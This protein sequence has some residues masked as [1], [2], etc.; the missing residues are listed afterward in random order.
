MA[1]RLVALWVWEDAQSKRKNVRCQKSDH[2]VF[3]WSLRTPPR[4]LGRSDEKFSKYR[5]AVSVVVVR[6]EGY[7]LDRFAQSGV[8]MANE[9][10]AQYMLVGRDWIM[11]VLRQ[12]R[13]LRISH[14][15]MLRD[16]VHYN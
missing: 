3:A 11:F 6:L 2:E 15:P 7:A 13:S 8:E 14:Y 5:N 9:Y 4:N 16:R 10:P 12:A 1:W